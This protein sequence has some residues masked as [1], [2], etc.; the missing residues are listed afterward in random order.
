[1]AKPIEPSR[2]IQGHVFTGIQ[3][4]RQ[5]HIPLWGLETGFPTLWHK[6]L[7]FLG[8]LKSDFCNNII[9]MLTYSYNNTDYD[10]RIYKHPLLVLHLPLQTLTGFELFTTVV[11]AIWAEKPPLFRLCA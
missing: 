3:D 7:N 11:L 1:M 9:H 2:S 4:G 5:G 8:L 6:F 10:A